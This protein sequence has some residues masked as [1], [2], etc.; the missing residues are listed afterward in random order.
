VVSQ[1]APHHEST[2]LQ[3]KDGQTLERLE[4]QEDAFDGG[5]SASENRR[6]AICVLA[7]VHLGSL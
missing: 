5:G 7:D 2:E 4:R 3:P 1:L 6:V